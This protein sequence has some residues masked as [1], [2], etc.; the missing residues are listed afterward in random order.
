M[1][2]DH[3]PT[4][5]WNCSLYGRTSIR[6]PLASVRQFRSEHFVQT[7]TILLKSLQSIFLLN[8]V[9][10][11]VFFLFVN[12]F[13]RNSKGDASILL[14]FEF[15]TQTSFL[16][17]FYLTQYVISPTFFHTTFR[18]QISYIIQ[19]SEILHF[20]NSGCKSPTIVLTQ[21]AHLLQL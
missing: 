19:S 11:K 12:F 6:P 4:L 7:E 5:S 16:L 2:V 14:H 10:E 8:F 1:A 3:F 20:I 9:Q 21:G 17:Q 13:G 15:R 18:I